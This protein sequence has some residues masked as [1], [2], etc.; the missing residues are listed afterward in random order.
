MSKISMGQYTSFNQ[1]CWSLGLSNAVRTESAGIFGAAG[2]N[3]PE[4][5]WDH[6]MP[7]GH[8]LTDT[9]QLTTTGANQIVWFDH[10]FD[11]RQM[12][13]DV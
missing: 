5:R 8:I 9:V 10:L 11:A 4:L 7:F 3:D 1:S 13:L 6:I 12:L 2:D